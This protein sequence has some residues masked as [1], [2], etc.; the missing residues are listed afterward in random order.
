MSNSSPIF[1]ICYVLKNLEH[2][3]FSN[4]F[5]IL[6]S[7]MGRNWEKVNSFPQIWSILQI[8]KRLFKSTF[9]KPL[10]SLLTTC[11]WFKILLLHSPVPLNILLFII[12]WCWKLYSYNKCMIYQN[13]DAL[14]VGSIFFLCG[15]YVFCFL[16]LRNFWKSCW[17]CLYLREMTKNILN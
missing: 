13:E 11:H 6:L 10:L 1:L 4:S 12:Q 9:V 17:T 15:E 14:G 3:F 5:L 16:V 8:L 2:F 7:K